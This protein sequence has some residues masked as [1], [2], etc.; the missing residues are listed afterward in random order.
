MSHTAVNAN[1][2]YPGR[3]RIEIS[4]DL[5]T[6]TAISGTVTMVEAPEYERDS[7]QV[8]V[9]GSTDIPIVTVG[10]RNSVEIAVRG[11]YT[12]QATDADRV[13]FNRFLTTT[14]TLA[15]RWKPRGEESGVSVY[16]TSVDGVTIGLAPIISYALPELDPNSADA[17]AFEFTV[18]TPAIIRYNAGTSTGLGS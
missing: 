12:D 6:W 8:F 15:V 2:F 5:S 3:F 16:A 7:Q 4:T 9:A 17:A 1:A 14:P 13:V 18:R 10:K 11:L